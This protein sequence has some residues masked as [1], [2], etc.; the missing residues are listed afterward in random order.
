[1][2]KYLKSILAFSIVLQIIFLKIIA[3]FPDVVEQLYSNGLYVYISKL[4][5]YV[6]GWVPFSVGD[7]L[8]TLATVY[9]L[10]WLFVNR[11][12][13][14]KDTKAW[15]LDVLSAVSIGYF[16]FHLLWAFNYYRL[17]LHKALNIEKD[18]TTEALVATT[19]RL[20]STVNTVHI[21]ITNNDT[22]KVDMPYSKTELLQK[23]PKGYDKLS[24]KF[25]HLAYQPKSV[26]RS[27]YSLPL[28]YMG[29]SGYL[30]PFTNEAQIDGL[31]PTFKY[32]TTASHEVAHQ[33]GYA[34][35][36]EAN[37]I[38]SMAAMHHD[39]IYFKYSGYAFALRHCLHEIYRRD[40]KQYETLVTK[41]NKGIL[42]NYQEVRDFW[43]SY[44]NPT[45]PLFKSTYDTFLKANNQIDGME[46]YSYV[47]ALLVNYFENNT[48]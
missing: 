44:Q 40:P 25:P 11:K 19:E 8:Y 41:V 12:R 39:D 24:K 6:F 9:I 27:I 28:T 45:E 22:V 29:F 3:R 26:K 34:A 42:K 14:I 1:M 33:L 10:R 31:I 36:N 21:A 5:R 32:P 30:N 23:V 2:Q 46:S 4:M 35:E 48:F 13:V 16:A 20:I 18:Y 15:I 38:G 37:F 47:V 17:P 43:D 7:I